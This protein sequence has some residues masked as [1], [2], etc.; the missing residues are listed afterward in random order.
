MWDSSEQQLHALH[1]SLWDG[2]RACKSEHVVSSCRLKRTLAPKLQRAQR[3][4]SQIVALAFGCSRAH[5]TPFA[6]RR[7]KN[8]GRYPT[9]ESASANRATPIALARCFQVLCRINQRLKQQAILLHRD[10]GGALR[11]TFRWFAT[12]FINIQRRSSSS[13]QTVCME[14]R[15]AMARQE[16]QKGCLGL[17]GV[18][19]C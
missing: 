15:K 9:M 5:G 18:L 6:G 19:K 8:A 13:S 1:D 12:S 14:P 10:A 2:S 16:W 11:D 3:R 7:F 4:W 17:S